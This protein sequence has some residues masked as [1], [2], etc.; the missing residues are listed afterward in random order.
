MGGTRWKLRHIEIWSTYINAQIKGTFKQFFNN[1]IVSLYIIKISIE[2]FLTDVT[3]LYTING[4][5]DEI[6]LLLNINSN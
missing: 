5:N 6:S 1:N 2:V 4:V 3:L